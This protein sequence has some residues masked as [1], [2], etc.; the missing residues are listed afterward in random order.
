M[1]TSR[2][3]VIFLMLLA[4]VLLGAAP[5][6]AQQITGVPGSPSA[7]VT[8]DGK[9]LPLPPMPYRQHCLVAGDSAARGLDLLVHRE[10]SEWE[11]SS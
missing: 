5:V 9:H 7:T 3:Y 8:L 6:S 11:P 10:P 2:T 1:N 4:A